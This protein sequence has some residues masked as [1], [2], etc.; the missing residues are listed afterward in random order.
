MDENGNTYLVCNTPEELK[1][2]EAAERT[3]LRGL[4]NNIVEQLGTVELERTLKIFVLNQAQQVMG[5]VIANCFGGW[6]YVSLL[7]VDKSLRNLGVG[8]QL[9]NLVEQEAVNIG[10]THAHLDT[11]SYEAR[12]FYEKLGYKLFATL[13]DYPPGYCKYFLQK[14]LS[15]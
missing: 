3:L 9:M 5:G 7:W 15:K 1:F 8:T 11:F 13:E 4:N 6:V 12:P 14:G 2:A 10:C